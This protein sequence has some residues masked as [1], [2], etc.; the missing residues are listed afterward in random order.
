MLKYNPPCPFRLSKGKC[1]ESSEGKCCCECELRE[2]CEE[3]CKNT[4]EKCG[5]IERWQKE[6]G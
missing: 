2:T 4:P 6:E 3:A 5:R 1:L